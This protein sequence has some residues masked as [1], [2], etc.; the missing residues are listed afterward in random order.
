VLTNT[1]YTFFPPFF[2][3]VSCSL[4]DDKFPKNMMDKGWSTREKIQTA[5]RFEWLS[6]F[7]HGHNGFDFEC[8]K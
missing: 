1:N 6:V 8:C 5:R 2:L 4:A 3:R 7:G